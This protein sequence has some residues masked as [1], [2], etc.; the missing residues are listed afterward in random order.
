MHAP[1]GQEL[2]LN[3]GEISSIRK[4]QAQADLQQHFA[5]GTKCIL[6]MT[7]GKFI[8]TTESCNEIIKA[9]AAADKE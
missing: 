4:P 1:D 5:K 3:I 9:I 6:V 8:S 7:N 2:V